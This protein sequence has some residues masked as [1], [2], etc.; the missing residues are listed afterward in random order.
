MATVGIHATTEDSAFSAPTECRALFGVASALL[1]GAL[2]L[3]NTHETRHE[4]LVFLLG[5]ITECLLKSIA[6]QSGAN[7][8]ALKK[9]TVR[10]NLAELWRLAALECT[11]LQKGTPP[12]IDALNAFH[13]D[14]Y[15]LRYMNGVAAYSLPAIEP[16]LAGVS[17]LQ[18]RAKEFVCVG[19]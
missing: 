12:W 8:R 9:Q 13:N 10:H 15:V 4:A 17:V 18:A 1:P 19:R 2:V 3:A 6:L 7:G 14:P 11:Q 16:V 5:H